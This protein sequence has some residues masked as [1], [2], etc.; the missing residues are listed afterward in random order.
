M[1]NQD[2][3]L[4]KAVKRMKLLKREV[5]SQCV[6]NTCLALL[7]GFWPFLQ[8]RA[9]WNIAIAY[10]LVIHCL[11]IPLAVLMLW[12]SKKS[13]RAVNPSSASSTNASSETA[14]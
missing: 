6:Q 12:P 7:F 11:I 13:S 14:K 2:A 8:V 5:T 3:S 1:Q 4:V 10:P 9:A